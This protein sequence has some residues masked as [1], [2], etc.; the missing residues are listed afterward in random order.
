MG[1][2]A[3]A[4]GGAVVGAV[5]G[6]F[7]G[8]PFMGAQIGWTLGSLAGAALFPPKG[9][10]QDGPRLNDLSFQTSG[11]GVPIALVAGRAKLAGNVIW[12]TGIEERTTTRRQGKGGGPRVT[13]Y[14]YFG[15]WAVGLCEWL[16]P[17]TNPAVLRIWLDN[18]LVYDTTGASD[19]TAIPGLSWR[20]YP[21]DETQLPDPLIEANVG[22]INAPAHR[23]LAYIVFEDVPL[24]RFGNRIPQVV[25][26]LA[27]EVTQSFPQVAAVAPPTTLYTS[28]PSTRVYL[29]A[30]QSFPVA[31]DF[32][33][34]RIYEGRSRVGGLTNT[35]QDELIRVYDLTTMQGISE[36][37]YDQVVEPLAGSGSLQ[38]NGAGVLHCGVDGFLYAAGGTSTQVPIFKINPD[39]MRAVDFFGASPI[40]A[41]PTFGNPG[42]NYLNAP[43]VLTSFQV[44]RPA[45]EPLTFLAGYGANSAC[46]I[47]NARTMEYVW[48]HVGCVDPLPIAGQGALVTS[49]QSAKIVPGLQDFSGTD[50]WVIIAPFLTSITIHRV[51]VFAGALAL[52]STTSMGITSTVMDTIDVPVELDPG[53]TR[54]EVMGAFWDPSD[55]S[56]VV[57]ITGAQVSFIKQR[58]TTFKWKSGSILWS[59]VNHVG[60]NTDDARGE[61]SR[62]LSGIWGRGGNL[63]LQPGTGDTLVNTAG[64]TWQQ[65]IAWL[66]EQR[67][68][69]GWTA[70]RAMVKRY[71]TRAAP[72]NLTV[73]TVVAALCQRAGLQVGDVNISALTDSLRGYMLARPMSARDAITPL[74]AYAHADVVEQDDVLVFRKRGGAPVATLAYDDLLREEP[75]AGVVEEQRAQ[76]ADLPATLTVRYSDIDR[77]YEQGAQSW[78]RPKAPTATMTSRSVAAMDLPIPLTA[79]EA[80]AAARR[81]CVATWRERTRLSFS[82]SLQ[83]ARLVPTDVITVGTRDGASIRCRVLSTQLGGNWQSRVEA[84]TED[85]AVYALTAAADGGGGWSQPTMPLPYFAQVLAPDMALVDDGDDLGQAALREYA[86]VAP[87]GAA[88]F[89]GVTV[90]E[91]GAGEPWEQIGVVTAPVEWGSLLETPPP[92]ASP[93]TWDEAGTLRVRM[94]SGQPESA[95]DLEVLNG[96]NRAALVA[97]DG[98]AEIVQWVNAVQGGDGTWTLS[99]LLRGRRGTEDLIASRSG[100]DRFVILDG[101]RL[102]Y[103]TP[104]AALTA[105]RDLKAVTIFQTADTAPTGPT[106]TARGRA[107]R[108]YAPTFVRGTRDGSQNLTITWLRR[109]RIGGE[110]LNGTDTVPLGEATQAYE[111]EIMFFGSVARTISGL[112]T[113]SAFYGVAEQITDFGSA[114]PSVT[115]RVYQ[116]SAIVGR[117]IPAEVTL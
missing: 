29:N 16:I 27:A 76:D 57:T 72:N 60:S 61:A 4:G 7:L 64:A 114:Q 116:I 47:I 101:T 52:T 6:T 95:T 24:D 10:N 88:Q 71:L 32:A 80:K 73:G 103:E 31:V 106:K 5:A 102:G 48:G 77:G 117:G 78:Q 65:T 39:T 109:T 19:V 115:V 87:Y 28:V 74:A 68:V 66:D 86:L 17:P 42:V 75:D 51:R 50:V 91:R 79:A 38:G 89:R 44:L 14:S 45:A 112:T 84:V 3:V 11:Y 105:P 113:P 40:G 81:M 83:H 15:N 53:A 37:R 23:G 96:A 2:L 36:H 62:V 56:L 69:V 92:P 107:E 67:A 34:G 90:I 97:G 82:V 1:Q 54:V 59:V 63:V 26:E 108:P 98:T 93:W 55:D 104:I 43:Y 30:F 25:V 21:G 13:S 58:F 49:G 20:F 9:P 35:P 33:R 85:A 111:V 22:T 94:T 12:S 100:G 46:Y 99:R 41:G 110:L 18:K 70:S 8:N